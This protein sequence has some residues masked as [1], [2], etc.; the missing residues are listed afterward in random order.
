MNN[1]KRIFFIGGSP[2]SGKSTVA[3]RISKEF[4]AYYFKVDDFL[5]E[6]T[7]SAADKGKVVCQKILMMSPDE[8]WL[9]DP[10]VQCDEEFLFYEEI[11]ESVFEKLEHVD[12]DFI[13]TEGAAYTPKIMRSYGAK[14]YISIIPT[15]EFQVSHYKER[16]W[17]PYV[18]EGCSDKKCAFDNWMKR[19]ILFAQRVE[20]AC[21][22]YGVPCIV[23]DGS[24][25]RDEM[26]EFVKK[27]MLNG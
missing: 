14:A 27:Y 5:D 9:R 24:I 13:V 15:A 22:E 2:C 8:I 7:K 11:S 1:E 19:D 18:L 3:E 17:V 20:A 10:I 26:F 23:N 25:S 21:G 12:A 16:E 6:F 4:G